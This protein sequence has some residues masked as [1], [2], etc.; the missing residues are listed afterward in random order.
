MT[1]PKHEELVLHG[2]AS[3]PQTPFDLFFGLPFQ[4]FRSSFP[5]FFGICFEALFVVSFCGCLV[6]SVLSAL[7]L[8]ETKC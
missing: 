5:K 6:K 8:C 2:I 7:K 4:I 1:D 3:N